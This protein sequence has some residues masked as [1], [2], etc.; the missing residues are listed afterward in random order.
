MVGVWWA[1]WAVCRLRDLWL[2]LKFP[3]FRLVLW[4]H[5]LACA[6]QRGFWL[7]T[8]LSVSFWSHGA[9]MT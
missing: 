1:R 3:D 7:F 5:W 6:L 2:N 9:A 4:P 8:G